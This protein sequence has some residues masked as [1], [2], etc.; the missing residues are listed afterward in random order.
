[1]STAKTELMRNLLCTRNSYY[2]ANYAIAMA[3]HLAPSIRDG[4]AGFDIGAFE[5]PKAGAPS[6]RQF[7]ENVESYTSANNLCYGDEL[8]ATCSD[9]LGG[10]I[11][12]YQHE[13]FEHI[14]TYVEATKQTSEFLA[15]P[16]YK[17]ARIIRNSFSHNWQIDAKKLKPGERAAFAGITITHANHG[18]AIAEIGL[19]NEHLRD[20][21]NVMI[22]FSATLK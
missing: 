21:V 2:V 16:W 17:F 19:T 18:G 9:V 22:E 20:L 12:R 4:S 1:M 10:A 5:G 11:R 7:L 15:Q 14:W 8:L 3:Y 13:V 6:F